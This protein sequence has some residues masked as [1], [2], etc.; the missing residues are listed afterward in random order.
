MLQLEEY[1]LDRYRQ[2]IWPRLL[3]SGFEV[4]GTL[5]I[6]TRIK[7]TT[8]VSLALLLTLFTL[9]LW[10][11]PLLGVLLLA[12]LPLL[13]PFLLLPA[14]W[15]TGVAAKRTRQLLLKKTKA[16][17]SCNSEV[18]IIMI[19]GSY[20]KTTVKY[21]LFELFRYTY[22]TALIPGNINTTLGIANYLLSHPEFL[23]HEY[24]IIEIGAY[25]KNDIAEAVSILSPDICILT[26]LGD[27]H[28]ERF[29]SLEG[30]AQAKYEIFSYAPE[31]AKRYA[32]DITASKLLAYGLSGHPIITITGTESPTDN[33]HIAQQV[34]EDCHIPTHLIGHTLETFSPPER[35]NDSYEL[36]GVSI[37]D[38]SYNISPTTAVAM[39]KAAKE[40]ADAMG[41]RLVVMTAGIG[42]Q[43]DEAQ[44][45]NAIFGEALNDYADRVILNPSIYAP[46]IIS[47]LE[48]E[49]VEVTTALTVSEN[50][51]SYVN[52]ATELLLLFPGHTDL[53][54]IQ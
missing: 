29:G 13:T 47:T 52:A 23:Q 24:L 48:K 17:R 25:Y 28:L 51:A 5:D 45:V 49:Y 46:A 43:G 19:T 8:L 12:L 53:S 40:Q 4:R 38:N 31:T 36:Q 11:L 9:A 6:T 39:L 32:T 34:A 26:A 7:T 35:R 15:L 22:K 2:Q 10:L 30:I 1:E 21:L 41:K 42:E 54:Y 18:K 33:Y 20:G 27:Q 37:I 3:R 14:S 50:P 16:L 44:T